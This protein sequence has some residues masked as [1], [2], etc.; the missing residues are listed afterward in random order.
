MAGSEDFKSRNFW[1]EPD[2]K[3]ERGEL[4]L[5]LRQRGVR[6]LRVL[7][8]ME[9]VPRRLF[10]SSKFQ[11]QAY[12]D[13]AL[14]IDCGQTIS[15]PHMVGMMTSILDIRGNH[16]VLEIGT[17]SGYQAAVLSQLAGEVYTVERFE[18]LLRLAR[19]RFDS[20]GLTTIHSRLSDGFDGW[21]EKA[22]FDRIV[23]TAAAPKVPQALLD[24]L[25]PD[26]I[27]VI[28]VGPSGEVQTLFKVTRENTVFSTNK[29]A[30]VRFVPMVEG[31]AEAL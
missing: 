7:R 31:V 28:P 9:R 25:K 26:G 11:K 2:S 18:T 20:L 24:Q 1:D 4:I 27:M 12:R 5:K 22:P 29:V 17:G 23:V 8:A 30:D 15:A 10:L 19:Q 14:P 21:P 6:D 3:E 13:R 16:K